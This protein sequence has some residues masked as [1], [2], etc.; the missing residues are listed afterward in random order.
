[1]RAAAGLALALLAPAA[2]AVAPAI[3][4]AT[5]QGLSA[6]GPRVRYE[7]SLGQPPRVLQPMG[8]LGHAWAGD[9]SYVAG[10]AR[11]SSGELIYSDYLYD[12]TGATLYPDTESGATWDVPDTR[13]TCTVYGTT[14]HGE[15]SYPSEPRYSKN[16]AD[17]AELRLGADDTAYYVLF[18]LQTLIEANTTVVALAIDADGDSATG[19]P[20]FAGYEHVLQVAGTARDAIAATLGGAPMPAVLDLAANTIEVRVPRAALPDGPWRITA[21][22]GTWSGT[23]WTQ[24]TD[25]AFIEEPVTGEMNC[26]HDRVQSQAIA[27]ARYPGFTFDPAALRAGGGEAAVV[28]H[29]PMVRLHR[30][31]IDLGEGIVGQPKYGQQSSADVYRGKLQ[32]YAAYVPASYDGTRAHPLIVLL[33]CLNCT[34]MTYQLVGWP[35]L[36][37]LAESLGAL[38]VTP[39]A[40]GQ[41]GH[42][43]EEAEWDVFD[44]LADVSARYRIDPERLYLSGMSMGSLGTF[45]LG[46]LYPD[47][48]AGAFGWGVYVDP[49]CSTPSPSAGACGVAPFS[50]YPL[51]DNFLNI[52]MGVVNGALD[53]LTPA[54]GAREIVG[55]FDTLGHAYRYFEYAQRQHEPRLVG[56]T[57]DVS[58]PWLQP[59]RRLR[60]PARVR[61]R[62]EPI[63]ENPGWGLTYRHAYWVRDLV[64]AEDAG[65][66]D[67]DAV[68]GRGERW[69]TSAVSGEGDNAEAG[70]YAFE[71]LDRMAAPVGDANALTLT[72]R[73]VQSL[74]VD[75]AAA[76]LT[77]DEQLTVAA[78][79]D[80]PVRL[81]LGD[82]SLNLPAGTSTQVVG[83]VSGSGVVIG[84]GGTGLALLV[85]ALTTALLRQRLRPLPREPQ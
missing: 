38:V 78:D 9:P 44:V 27:D 85:L 14:R 10:T 67:V 63:I 68:S 13:G 1:M 25:L 35:G 52:P 33:H 16:A 69:S 49:Q 28:R 46:S 82:R 73:G 17:L 23:A 45:R 7:A 37:A 54:A 51:L 39:L 83:P 36:A 66:V 47:L 57:H 65:L 81:S 19:A 29:G 6:E 64:F 8:R 77:L 12:D 48:W 43:E 56:L 41:G 84:T 60:Q 20:G 70:P 2:A 74:R 75:L 18:Q 3:D 30:P 22:T 55:R 42:Y 26:W 50:Y 40:Y 15:Y 21:A 24:V 62:L 61:W 58:A 5:V 34:H 31:S 32:P 76:R 80:L 59:L 79:V 53:P 72:L 71:G 4:P 11:R